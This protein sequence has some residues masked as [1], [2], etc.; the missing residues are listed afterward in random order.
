MLDKTFRLLRNMP[1]L[2]RTFL[3]NSFR[4]VCGVAALPSVEVFS[5]RVLFLCSSAVVVNA[6]GVFVAMW[7]VGFMFWVASL[8]CVCI[9]FS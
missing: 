2:C 9:G 4:G 1:P 6:L 8:W 5:S 7:G 3:I